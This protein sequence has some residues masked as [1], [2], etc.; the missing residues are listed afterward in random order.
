MRYANRTLHW[1]EGPVCASRWELPGK[2][3]IWVF[4]DRHRLQL[5]QQPQAIKNTHRPFA[6]LDHLLLALL[7]RR[8]KLAVDLYVEQ[9]PPMWGS[10]NDSEAY[11]GSSS[12]YLDL[13][14]QTFLSCYLS[15]VQGKCQTSCYFPRLRLWSVDVRKAHQAFRT[16]LTVSLAYCRRLQD[17]RPSDKAHRAAWESVPRLLRRALGTALDVL[18]QETGPDATFGQVVESQ[19][20]K[21]GAIRRLQKMGGSKLVRLVREAS[22]RTSPHR[23]FLE[24]PVHRVRQW[25]AQQGSLSE[26]D[27]TGLHTMLSQWIPAS[28]VVM[29]AFLL[30]HVLEQ[31]T[32]LSLIF[33]GYMHTQAIEDVL[34]ASGYQPGWSTPRHESGLPA[35][36]SQYLH[37]AEAPDLDEGV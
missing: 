33:V 9:M 7:Q 21:T 30:S 1:L 25:V 26:E 13:L 8:P 17:F 34:R 6:R 18:I 35:S 15:H 28:A 32:P 36:L 3:V 5:C 27:M 24:F 29:D 2:R 4:G 31:T 20:H 11:H 22:R 19:L 14:H 37:V 16:T 10:H 12:T 23:A